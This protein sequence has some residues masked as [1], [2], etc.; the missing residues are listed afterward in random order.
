MATRHYARAI[1][2]VLGGDRAE[3]R[4]L[5]AG[6]YL[7]REVDRRQAELEHSDWAPGATRHH[8]PG[9]PPEVT[10]VSE[11]F[12]GRGPKGMRGMQ[13]PRTARILS[14]AQA[15]AALTADDGGRLSPRQ[16]L[17]DLDTWAGTRYDPAV[18]R[19][20]RVAL[21]RGLVRT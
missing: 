4:W 16:A 18:V 6:T 12:D 5:G 1:S 14:V 15:L 20:A 19:A 10:L 3:R 21:A 8:T 17:R 13:I 2:F 9:E 11:W 7:S